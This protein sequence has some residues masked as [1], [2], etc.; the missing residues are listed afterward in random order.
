ME[1]SFSDYGYGD[2]TD[3]T[4][5]GKAH[6]LAI[7][8]AVTDGLKRCAKNLGP[9]MGLALYDKDQTDVKEAETKPVQV[10][11]VPKAK[12]ETK[13]VHTEPV[14]PTNG[15]QPATSSTKMLKATLKSSVKVLIAQNKITPIVF[16]EAYANGKKVDELDEAEL[17]NAYAKIKTTYPE[18][19]LQ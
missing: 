4:N 15:F 9:V 2:G 11:V 1:F 8:E 10:A 18:L 17:A 19:G 16:K 6:E 13:P 14:T 3:K 7:K 5:P 12:E